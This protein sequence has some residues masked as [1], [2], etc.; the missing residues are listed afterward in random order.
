MIVFF[1]L[2]L[3]AFPAS[4]KTS[5]QRYS[6]TAPMYTPAPGLTRAA[7]LPLRMYRFRRAVGNWRPALFD[8]DES[9]AAALPLP[10]PPLPLP[11]MVF[12]CDWS[13]RWQPTV[14]RS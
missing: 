4:S 10:R 5:A 7:Y 8:I 2:S 12:L 1:L 13:R 9:L 14:P 11:D 6:R 3:A